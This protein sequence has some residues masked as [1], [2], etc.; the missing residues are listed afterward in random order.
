MEEF[1]PF[2]LIVFSGVFFSMLSIRTHIPWAV[3]LII[4][5]IVVGPS[6][7]NVISINPTIDFMGQIGLVFLMFMAGL[8]TKF[9]QFRE[10]QKSLLFLAFMNGFIPFLVG[11]A[12]IWLLGY[13]L[14][15]S[16]IVGIIFVSSSIAVVIPSLEI[17]GVLHTKLGQSVVVT[18]VIQDITSLVLLSLLLQTVSPVTEVPLYVFYPVLFGVLIALRHFIPK[19]RSWVVKIATGSPDVFQL[20]FRSTFLVLIGTVIAF[21]LLGLHPIVAGFFSGL[22][23]ADSIKSKILKEKIQTISY[24]VFIPT[25]FIVIGLQTDMT[26]FQDIRSV[27]LVMAIII[28]S[29]I[30]S[31]YTSGYFAARIVGFDKLESNF[32]AAT[33]LPQLSTTLATAFV[34]FS[35]GLI[36]QTLLT[37]LVILSIVTVFLSPILIRIYSA[38]LSERKKLK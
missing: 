7:L 32:F 17:S 37:S 28:V 34:A 22:V 30:V 24:G 23:L 19:L 8:E 9:S 10:F 25:F 20:E 36:D 1:Y 13:D 11:G 18:T 12:V 31:K 14:M 33:S 15:T 4:G 27:L 29:L 2:F 3:M 6:F 21:E 26:I 16:L 38:R 35:L 5:G